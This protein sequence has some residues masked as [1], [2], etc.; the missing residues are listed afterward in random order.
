MYIHRLETVLPDFQYEQQS[1][2]DWMMDY[3]QPDERNRRILKMIYNR[4]KVST[5]YSVLPDFG[6]SESLLFQEGRNPTVK[7]RMGVYH[8]EGKKMINRIKLDESER[9][10]ITDVVFIS[11]TGMA[12]PGM[13]IAVVKQLGLNPNVNRLSI[14]YMG[15]YAFVTG[16]RQARHICR[17]K[18]G[19][20]VLVISL[21]LCT[22]HLQKSV[23]YDAVASAALFADGMAYAIVGTESDSPDDWM[24]GESFSALHG[25]SE[26]MM[27]WNIT[28][29][30][31]EM[32]LNQEVPEIIGQVCSDI[33]YKRDLEWAIHPG[34]RKILESFEKGVGVDSNDL[35]PSYDVMEQFGNM[36]SS[37]IAFV[38]DRVLNASQKNHVQALAFGP[39]LVAEGIQINRQ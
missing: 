28:T 38:L 9:S 33:D 25:N 32:G 37:T 8:Q 4:S 18:S 31:F 23:S 22:L 1:L 34:G 12:A 39:G 17:S 29:T 10:T 6:A 11:C 7:S 36:S 24:I 27:S 26:D 19:S 2:S 35:K 3:L 21:E 14:H 13:D 15:C 16:L 5:R 20:K 30:G